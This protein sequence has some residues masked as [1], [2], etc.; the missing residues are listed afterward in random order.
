MTNNWHISKHIQKFDNVGLSEVV[1]YNTT[2]SL[3][4]DSP[5]SVVM[6]SLQSKPKKTICK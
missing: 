1:R 3:L 2:T 5:K 6:K 4:F